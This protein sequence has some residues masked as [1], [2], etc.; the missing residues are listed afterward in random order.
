MTKGTAH[1]Y[2][3]VTCGWQA[4]RVTDVPCLRHLHKY[5]THIVLRSDLELFT[6]QDQ[7]V[8]DGT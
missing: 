4:Q 8:I 5:P 1:R 6:W 2:A 7:R 3:C